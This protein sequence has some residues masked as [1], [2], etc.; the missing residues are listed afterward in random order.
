LVYAKRLGR[1]FDM[2]QT[3]G[4]N[5]FPAAGIE[6]WNATIVREH[7]QVLLSDTLTRFNFEGAL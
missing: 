2:R 6:S 1:T 3:C 4:C 7:E 5:G